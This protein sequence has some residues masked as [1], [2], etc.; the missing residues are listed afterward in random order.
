MYLFPQGL[1]YDVLKQEPEDKL[2]RVMQILSLGVIV[3]QLII[4]PATI[5]TY[6][7]DNIVTESIFLPLRILCEQ[8][9]GLEGI[10]LS[11]CVNF[12][13][14]LFCLV[15]SIGG[16]SGVYNIYLFVDFF[17]IYTHT[18]KIWLRKIW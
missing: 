10:P 1:L 17:L 11:I 9:F 6:L 8:G 5:G 16:I 14:V 3:L 7:I 12:V 2:G 13:V 15:T 18:T 4:F